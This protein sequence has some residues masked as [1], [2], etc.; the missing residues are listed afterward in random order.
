MKSGRLGRLMFGVTLAILVVFTSQAVEAA[1]PPGNSVQQWNK[2]SEDT[3]FGS[4]AF[5]NEGLIYMAYV[6]A[7]VYDAVVAIE[8]RYEPYGTA[9]DA[10]PG[11]SLDAAVVEA[12]YRTLQNYFPSQ[13]A[14]L[15]ALHTE[16]LALIPDG[17]SK[18]DGKAVGIA[19][20][21]GII[22]LRT[23]DG[24]MTPI[25]VTSTFETK[26][27]AP[28]VWRLTPPFAPPQTPWIGSVQPFIL[29]EAGQFQPR[30]PLPLT[31]EQWVDQFNEIK[32]YGRNTGSARTPEQTSIALFWTANAIRQYNRVARDIVSARGLSI[33]ETARL[34]AMINVVAADAQISVMH[35]KYRFLFW[36]PVTA[37]DPSA[38]VDDG[39]G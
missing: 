14:T 35:S 30:Q 25:G 38:V 17:L 8:G 7:A 18:D 20:A 27:P 6:S 12:A 33:L 36:R 32:L 10:L 15:D 28:G 22:A 11:A 16:A 24:R 13:A 26:P 39:F 5:G 2:I 23:G 34:A 1:L 9:I 4:G 19:A 21:E 3:V 31:S 37:I 29:K